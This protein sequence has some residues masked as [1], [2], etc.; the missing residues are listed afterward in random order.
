MNINNFYSSNTYLS[1]HPNLHIEDTEFKF[2]K[3]IYILDNFISIFSNKNEIKILDVGGGNGLILK[4]LSKYINDKYQIKVNKILLDLSPE[5][6]EIQKR[7]NPDFT[8]AVCG[9]I[10][11]TNFEDNSFDLVLLIDVL[12]HIP[13]YVEALKEI[14]RISEYLLL[15]VPLEKNLLELIYNTLTLGKR[16]KYLINHYGH[17]HM[18]SSKYLIKTL[19]KYCGEIINL[20]YTN[21]FEFYCKSEFY[22]SNL[23]PIRKFFNMIGNIFYKISPYLTSVLFND[24][25]IVLIKCKK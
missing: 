25:L 7:T 2:Q 8:Q 17:I 16:R 18:F 15:K 21:V 23:H 10:T 6:L 13:E 24:F 5:I 4:K 3:L 12:E 14:K 22:K 1:L 19:N 20:S 11:N 9:S